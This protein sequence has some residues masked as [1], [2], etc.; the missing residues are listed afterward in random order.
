MNPLRRLHDFGQSPWYDN[1]HRKMLTSGELERMIQEDGVRG[2]TSNPTIFQN[3][4]NNSH[5]YDDQIKQLLEEYPEQNS[6]DL[7]FSLAIT[8]I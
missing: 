6:R 5:N 3:A 2:I 7:F 1:I 8:Y 4:I